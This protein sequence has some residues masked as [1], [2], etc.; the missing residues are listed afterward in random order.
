MIYSREPIIE[1]DG[2]KIFSEE[3]FYWQRSITRDQIKSL[4]KELDSQPIMGAATKVGINPGYISTY[5]RADMIYFLPYQTG[6]DFSVLDLGAGFGNITIPIAKKMPE[7]QIYAVDASLDILGV[8]SKQARWEKCSN[9]DFIKTDIVEKKNLP[10]K[11]K[12]FDLIIMNGVLEWVGAGTTV[13]N[14]REHQVEVLLYL[15]SLLKENGSLYIGIEGRFFPGYFTK[16]RDPHSGLRFTSVLPRKIADW[17]C[18]KNGMAG[19][20]TYIYSHPG[21][22]KLF[23]EAG[24]DTQKMETI[25]PVASYKDPYFLF[26]YGDKTAYNFAFNKIAK[27]IFPAPRGRFLFQF[28][29]Y[30]GLE[31]FFAPSYLFILNNKE[32]N[33]GRRLLDHKVGDWVDMTKYE[34]IKVFGNLANFGSSSFWLIDKETK[35]PKYAVKIKRNLS[36]DENMMRKVEK[37]LSFNLPQA[38]LPIKYNNDTQLFEFINGKILETNAESIEKAIYVIKDIHF[39]NPGLIHGDYTLANILKDGESYKIIDWDDYAESESQFFDVCSLIIHYFFILKHLPVNSTREILTS[40]KV[41]A[42]FKKY[43]ERIKMEDLPTI[44]QSFL[45]HSVEW[46]ENRRQSKYNFYSSILK[47]MIK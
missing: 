27:E 23:K 11:E 7:A 28:L 4:Q 33:N 44:W 17:W 24:F 8:A 15:K 42:W 16:V 39:K 9:I 36:D 18:R 5:H 20:R 37:L 14:P 13:G 2:I 22:S 1:K 46:Y 6:A 40:P 12:S 26:S 29:Y 25:Y 41:L 10:F 31:K 3:D 47:I 45:K 43:D 30:L 34:P 19:Y 32:S 21:Y 35:A 38:V